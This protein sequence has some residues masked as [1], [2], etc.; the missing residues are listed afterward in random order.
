M[1]EL[2]FFKITELRD[3]KYRLLNSSYGS[4]KSNLPRKGKI[5]FAFFFF[6]MSSRVIL[7][8]Q[9]RLDQHP[10]PV[11]TEFGTISRISYAA[12]CDIVLC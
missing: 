3:K 5:V 10:P 6:L 4:E 7:L 11:G 8:P 1:I 9:E 12:R 2:H